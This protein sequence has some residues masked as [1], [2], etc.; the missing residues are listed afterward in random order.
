DVP[1]HPRGDPQGGLAQI[2]GGLMEIG[3]V[4]RRTFLRATAVAG[5]GIMLGLYYESGARAQAPAGDL[6]ALAPGAF[7]RIAPDGIATIM[8]KNPEL[9]QSIKVLLPMLI[10][11]ELD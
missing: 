1:A 11:E 5:G 6:S 8:A 7:V 4:D 10:A 2:A 9:G 3:G